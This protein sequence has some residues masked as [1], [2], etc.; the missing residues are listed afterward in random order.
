MEIV[1]RVVYRQNDLLGV[2]LATVEAYRETGGSVTTVYQGGNLVIRVGAQY[3]PHC[4]K[5][6]PASVIC[7]CTEKEGIHQ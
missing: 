2:L 7:D 3:C 4:R 6:T 5:I 1:D